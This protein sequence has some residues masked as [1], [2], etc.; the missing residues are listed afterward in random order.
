MIV[1][2]LQRI[3]D[4]R[5]GQ[6]VQ[7]NQAVTFEK[8]SA[9][10]SFDYS[11]KVLFL[12]NRSVGKSCLFKLLKKPGYRIEEQNMPLT[13]SIFPVIQWFQYNSSYVKLEIADTSGEE[14]F[15]SLTS[16]YYRDVDGVFL[17]YD[18][19][20]DESF[21]KLPFWINKL[22]TYSTKD[23]IQMLL[24]GN[25]LDLRQTM[26]PQE[27]VQKE[28]ALAFANMLECPYVETSA[29]CIDSVMAMYKEMVDILISAVSHEDV[30]IQMEEEK[31]E[32]ARST[33]NLFTNSKRKIWNFVS[34]SSCKNS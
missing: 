2:Y 12:G 32:E 4:E 24:V 5:Q 3:K 1:T 23:N 34:C 13:M 29:K 8:V 26:E 33:I 6:K 27:M 21:A 18:V 19:S 20:C 9:Q 7:R 16:S 25:K 30:R 14:R 28:K 22:R 31:Q 15:F 17:T 10:P 11:F